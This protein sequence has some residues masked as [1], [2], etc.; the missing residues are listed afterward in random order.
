MKKYDEASPSN[1]LAGGVFF[2]VKMLITL[3]LDG[4]MVYTYVF[5]HCPATG[6]QSGD[7]ASPSII[8]VGRALLMKMFITLELCGLFCSNL[9]TIVF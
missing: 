9:Y 7:R 6:M 4:Q 3:E 1:I 5:L 2:L 8:L